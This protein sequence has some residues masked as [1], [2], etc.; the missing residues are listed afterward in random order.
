MQSSSVRIRAPCYMH[1]IHAPLLD[2]CGH[3][4]TFSLKSRLLMCCTVQRTIESMH[5]I[6]DALGLRRGQQAAVT[7]GRLIKLPD[8]A[9]LSAGEME[10]MQYVAYRLQPGQ[11]VRRS[12][13]DA[14]D[15][16][17]TSFQSSEGAHIS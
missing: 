9:V 15:S 6:C 17:R 1:Q 10:L 5:A 16:H 14:Q 11:A 13:M 12:L 3:L 7:N 4:A 2:C 8:D